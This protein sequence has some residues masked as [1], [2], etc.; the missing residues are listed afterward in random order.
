MGKGI[1]PMPKLLLNEIFYS[2]QGEGV[3]AGVPTIFIRFAGCNLLIGCAWCDTSYAQRSKDGKEWE[4]QAI[5]DE[6]VRLEPRTYQHW[7]CITGGEPLFQEEGLHELV[8]KLKRYGYRVEIETNGSIEKPLW[9]TIADCWV[10]DIK[11]PSSGVS[12]VSKE[13]W[14]ESRF[15]DQ[16]KFVVG[17]EED[18]KFAK[19]VIC[20]SVMRS[21][22]I[23]VSPVTKVKDNK[24]IWDVKWLQR[25]AEFCKELNVRY[26]LQ[27]HKILWGNRKGV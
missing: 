5:L 4:I 14:L 27:L 25:V 10:A 17:D 26:S 22:I 15:N 16:V 11:C 13:D 12:G 3:Y 18:L 9:W 7:V 21:P 2:L 6:C 23:L 19:K 20:G 1:N 24:V 8:K